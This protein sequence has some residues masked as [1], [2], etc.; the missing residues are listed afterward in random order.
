MKAVILAGGLGTRISEETTVKPK[1]MVE[2]G[3]KPILWHIMKTY[4]HFG[5]NDFVICL[6][7]KGYCIKEYFVNYCMHNS[8]LTVDLGRNSVE[9]LRTP[10]EPWRINLVDTGDLTMTGGRVRRI[11]PYVDGTFML[12]YGDGVAD[13]DIEALLRF[14]RG[15]GKLATITAVHPPSKYGVVRF[16]GEQQVSSF[17]EK[18]EGTS[19]YINAGFM[20]FEPEIFDYLGDDD[21]TML[22][23]EPFERL[24]ADGQMRAFIHDGFWKCMDTLRDKKELEH[25]WQTFPQWKLW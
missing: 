21:G 4:S 22:E 7:Y 10:A 2:I 19:S 24:A 14:H 17:L 5:I 13:I 3:G 23:R 9:F 16:D 12:T 8:D 18:P 20:V 11:R 15:H 1:P 25:L 6:G